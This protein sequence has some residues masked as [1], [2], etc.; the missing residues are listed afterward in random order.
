M[1]RIDVR[2]SKAVFVSFDSKEFLESFEFSDPGFPR[3][4]NVWENTRKRQ[5]ELPIKDLIYI[6]IDVP[7]IGSEMTGFTWGTG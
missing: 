6:S 3:R 5:N 2:A 7:S 1:V 4:Y